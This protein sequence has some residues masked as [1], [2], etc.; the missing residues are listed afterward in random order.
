MET[1]CSIYVTVRKSVIKNT[2]NL[3]NPIV[4]NQD[5]KIK[6]IEEVNPHLEKDLEEAFV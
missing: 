1:P 3:E 2:N 5:D 4:V 6:K